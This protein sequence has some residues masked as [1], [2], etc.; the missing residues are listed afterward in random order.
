MAVATAVLNTPDMP[1]MILASLAR[2]FADSRHYEQVETALVKYID[3]VPGNVDI[4]IDLAATHAG[5]PRA[6]AG[7]RRAGLIKP[8][9]PRGTR[10]PSR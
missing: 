4:W 6:A 9:R 8:P 10:W 2:L 7:R 1:P 5:L 3:L